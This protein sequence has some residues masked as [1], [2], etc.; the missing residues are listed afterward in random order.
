[1]PIDGQNTSH[2]GFA[3]QRFTTAVDEEFR[4]PICRDV[5]DE[6]ITAQCEHVFCRA[7]IHEWLSREQSC[8]VGRQ[9]LKVHHLQDVTRFF[10]NYYTK[11]EICCDFA[12]SGCQFVA[13]VDEIKAHENQC[14]FNPDVKT[15]CPN[16]CTAMV[17]KKE[18]SAHDCVQY[19]KNIIADKNAEISRMSDR[20][21][22]YKR[23]LLDFQITIKTKNSEINYLNECLF[24]RRN[25]TSDKGSVIIPSTSRPTASDNKQRIPC[26][27]HRNQRLPE[28]Y[29]RV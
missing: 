12:D 18:L 1:R 6:P 22:D 28:P 13:K 8:P 19:L 27:R 23:K 15:E 11:L 7:C 14:P 17:T 25:Q 24:E 9:P 5:L 26:G 2:M 16:G 4:C 3:E 20:E 21:S 10:R 29:H